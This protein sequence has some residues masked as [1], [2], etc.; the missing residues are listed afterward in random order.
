MI[1]IDAIAEVLEID[2]E[3]ISKDVTIQSI[4]FCLVNTRPYILLSDL[5]D[6]TTIE[7]CLYLH[8]GNICDIAILH[9]VIIINNIVIPKEELLQSEENYLILKYGKILTKELSQ[10]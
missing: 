6:R 1:L 7:K 3:S 8:L 4:T 9:D 2:F 5:K 10:D